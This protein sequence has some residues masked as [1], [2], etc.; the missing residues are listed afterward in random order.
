MYR[1]YQKIFIIKTINTLLIVNE[2][3]RIPKLIN[4]RVLVYLGGT[5]ICSGNWESNIQIIDLN[6]KNGIKTMYRHFSGINTMCL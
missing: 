4:T 2:I 1:L 3:I 6:S 5:K